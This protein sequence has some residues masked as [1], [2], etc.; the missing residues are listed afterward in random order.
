M[1]NAVSVNA[2]GLPID[3][4]TLEAYCEWLHM[5]KR[6][7]CQELY[8][9]MGADA[10]KMTPCNTIAGAFHIPHDGR[11]WRDMPKPSTRARLVL[12][13]VGILPVPATEA[14]GEQ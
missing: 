7:L 10:G 2:T 4:E 6:L 5:E 9:E 8:P 14:E 12:Q 1:K 13:A 11:R 3:R